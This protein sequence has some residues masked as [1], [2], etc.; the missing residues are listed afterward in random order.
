MPLHLL[1]QLHKIKHVRF[2]SSVYIE[3][4]KDLRGKTDLTELNK[5]KF[6]Y[7]T[8]TM[9]S[10]QFNKASIKVKKKPNKKTLNIKTKFLYFLRQSL[11]TRGKIIR[12]TIKRACYLMDYILSFTPNIF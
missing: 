3:N 12:Y 8:K 6:V 10:Q 1:I 4:P 2:Q 7:L 5:T 9:A 11:N